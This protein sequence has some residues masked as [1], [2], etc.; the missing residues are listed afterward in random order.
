MSKYGE[1]KTIK[2]ISTGGAGNII[3]ISKVTSGGKHS[4][5]I[6]RMYTDDNGDLQFISKGVRVGFD[7]LLDVVKALSTMLTSAEWDNL[8]EYIE[9]APDYSGDNDGE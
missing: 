5:D 2:D 4:A 3:R 9:D 1:S 8:M 6:R 7:N